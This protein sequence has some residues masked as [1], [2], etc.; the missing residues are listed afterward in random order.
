[1]RLGAFTIESTHTSAL[2]RLRVTAFAVRARL[3]QWGGKS[4]K[5]NTRFRPED[6]QEF[7][8]KHLRTVNAT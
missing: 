7:V 2:P 8:D 6:L 5:G 3:V 1:M 4:G